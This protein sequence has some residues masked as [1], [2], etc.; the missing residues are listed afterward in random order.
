MDKLSKIL[1]YVVSGLLLMTI[2][3]LANKCSNDSK[4]NEQAGLINSL[5]DTVKVWK[6]KD[7]LSHSSNSVVTTRDPQD[8]IKLKGQSEEIQKLQAKVKEYEK[9]IKN[10]GS[11]TNFSS[12]TKTVTVTKTKVDTVVIDNTKQLVYSSDFNKE[13]WVVGDVV[14]RP[15]STTVNLK[16]KNEYTVVIGYDKTG[17]L[18]L[19]KQ[20]PFSEITNLNPYSTTPTL[21]TYQVDV[22]RRNRAVLPAIALG[23]GIVGGILISK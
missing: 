2:L 23:I 16:V 14:A 6:G 4:I 10:G 17:F 9:K 3:L 12:E 1:M 22:K 19:G 15:D 7:G 11:V 20:V 18:G 13:D 8:F 5:N 21:K